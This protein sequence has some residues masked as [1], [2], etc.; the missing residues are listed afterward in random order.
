MSVLPP[1]V[2]TIESLVD[3]YAL[4]LFDQFGVLHDGVVPV[5]GRRETLAA[6]KAAGR[7][8][9]VITNSGKRAAFNR[10]R[11]VQFGYDATLVDVV[12]SSGEVAW[13]LLCGEKPRRVFV[14]GRGGNRGFLDSLPLVETDDVSGCELVLIAG[15]E[16]ERLSLDDY[17]ARLAPAARRGTPALCTN[18]DHLMLLGDGRT[19]FA[20]GQ[21]ADAYADLG[22]A[23]RR[24]GKPWP[25]IYAHTLGCCGVDPG[26]TLCIGDSVEHD[27]GG[28]EAAGCDSLLVRTG[29]HADVPVAGL[30]ALFA[31]EGHRPTWLEAGRPV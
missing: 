5:R 30:E 11:L 3:R 28:A 6:I 13:T 19:G 12:V 31:A 4:F 16:P 10:E 14:I 2:P 22:G 18:P 17:R 20:A 1:S 27:I 29:I 9:G 21:I 7:Q 15:A 25:E 26:E 24:L 8:V 23:V